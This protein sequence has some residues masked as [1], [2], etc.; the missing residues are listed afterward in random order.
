VAFDPAFAHVQAAGGAAGLLLMVLTRWRCDRLP[1]S[2]SDD[3][4]PLI[5][6]AAGR[7]GRTGCADAVLQR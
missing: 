3:R 7:V 6:P 2:A 1:A 5:I 4:G